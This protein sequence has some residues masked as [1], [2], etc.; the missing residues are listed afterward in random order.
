MIHLTNNSI[1]LMKFG[2]KKIF[3]LIK[4]IFDL[5]KKNFNLSKYDSY[6]FI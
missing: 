1:E 4:K 5:I 3:D 6:R 2:S